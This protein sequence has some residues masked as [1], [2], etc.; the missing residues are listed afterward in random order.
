MAL[1]IDP[2]VDYAFKLL[3]GS[4]E[5]PAITLHFLNAILGDEIHI[6]EVEILNPILGKEDDL[7]KLSILDVSARDSAGRL[8]DIEM[9][10]TLP[11]G[12]SQ[13]L[14]YYTASLYISQI[15]EGDD[16]TLLRPAISICVL[17]AI[18]FRESAQIHSDF[19]LRSRDGGL[20]LTD[21][22]QIHL[23]ELPKYTV[24]SDNR[25]ITDPVDAWCHF[26]R[27]AETM[28]AEEIKQRFNSPAFSE[29]A[30]VLDMIQR[31]PQQRSQY[32]LRL[33]A[34]RD[35][36][37]RMQF[38]V[39]QARKEG[40]AEGEAVGEARCRIKILHELLSREQTSVENLSLD[41]LA[42]LEKDLQRQLRDRGV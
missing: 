32:E 38:A 15:G 30:E 1:G 16:Y 31:T 14:A 27:R 40:K 6:V 19:R 18:L 8:Y 5:H 29:A 33:K 28:T 2:T 26:F 12:L 23:L 13:R 35:E 9:Q 22:L 36:R 21:G 42:T 11:A 34:Q 7:D 25:V 17:D 24:P 4:P 41:E 39:E 37:A 10:T 3:L 20:K